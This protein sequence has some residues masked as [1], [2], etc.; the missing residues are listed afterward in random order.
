MPLDDGR[1]AAIATRPVV[2]DRH[3]P[4]VEIAGVGT[5][6]RRL[7]GGACVAAVMDLLEACVGDDEPAV[8]EDEMPREP[9]E[10]R[11]HLFPDRG[12]FGSD[13]PE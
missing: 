4:V 6:D 8:I 10:E 5:M 13:L 11:C 9:G 7:A 2:A 1:G 12:R 3:R